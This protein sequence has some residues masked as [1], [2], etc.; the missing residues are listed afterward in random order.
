LDEIA[1]LDGAAFDEVISKDVEKLE[2]AFG[3]AARS[4]S[5]LGT[6]NSSMT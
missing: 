6:A 4:G 5:N 1:L 2:L 3:S